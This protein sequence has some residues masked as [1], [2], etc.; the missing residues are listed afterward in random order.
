MATEDV[1]FGVVEAFER[2][3]TPPRVTIDVSHIR[4]AE[5]LGCD[6]VSVASEE[7]KAQI[8]ERGTI[9]D[10]E[11]LR[12]I[13]VKGRNVKTGLVELTE[14]ELDRAEQ[15]RDRY[16][17][18]RVFV[19]VSRPGHFE[20]AVLRDPTMSNAVRQV[21]RLD[22]S[23]GSGAEWFNLDEVVGDDNRGEKA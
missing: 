9:E 15:A 12:Y 7:L 23:A 1:T 8:L 3:A 22:L 14:N 2:L 13:E 6:L 11:I 18:Y 21:L 20:I 4:G 10:S 17:V 19:D 5:G 16:F